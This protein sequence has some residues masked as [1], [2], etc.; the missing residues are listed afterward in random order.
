LNQDPYATWI[1]K[2]E[3]SFDVSGLLNAQDYTKFLEDLQ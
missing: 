2:V 1:I 3:G